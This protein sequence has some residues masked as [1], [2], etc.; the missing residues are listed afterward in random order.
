[1]EPGPNVQID[2]EP[3]GR[4]S[5]RSRL[6]SATARS[7]DLYIFLLFVFLGIVD[8]LVCGDIVDIDLDIV[9]FCTPVFVGIVEAPDRAFLN[10]TFGAAILRTLVRLS[11]V[12]GWRV[13]SEVAVASRSLRG[14]AAG[15]DGTWTTESA[16]P[17]GAEPARSTRTRSAEAAGPRSAKSSARSRSAGSAFLAGPRFAD[18]ERPALEWLLVESLDRFFRDTAIRIVDER[19]T[20]RSSGLPIYGQYDRCGLADARQVRSQLCLRGGIRQIANEQTD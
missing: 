4:A 1:L 17:R 19:E 9:V 13:R 3:V 2:D 20:S 7:L 18:G 8:V 12:L 15:V 5:V 10:R 6:T 11:L 16:G 14:A